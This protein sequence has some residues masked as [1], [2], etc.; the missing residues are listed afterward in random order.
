MSKSIKFEESQLVLLNSTEYIVVSQLLVNNNTFTSQERLRCSNPSNTPDLLVNNA[1]QL[2]GSGSRC[3]QLGRDWTRT[4]IN[5]GTIGT[6]TSDA[7]CYQVCT[8]FISLLYF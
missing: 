2:Y 3:F 6:Y 8:D 7:G 1:G 4:D 5:T